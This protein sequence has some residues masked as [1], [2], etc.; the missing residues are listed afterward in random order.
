[1][2]RLVFKIGF[3]FTILSLCYSCIDDVDFDQAGDLAVTTPLEVSLIYFEEP[4][5]TFY[6]SEGVEQLVVVD[7]TR[8][9]IFN[10]DFVSDNLVRAN[11]LFETTNSI[12]RIFE[13]KIDFLDEADQELRAI[14]FS[15]PASET[16]QP[17]VTIH[18]EIFENETLVDLKTTTQLV[19]TLTMLAN[20]DGT[21]LNENS[22]GVIKMRSKGSFYINVISP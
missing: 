8:V 18:E 16:G 5:A 6:V 7:S 17:Q 11:F 13:A 19:L 1:M 15:V 2:L 10:D 12:N 4:A 21:T 3:F 14:E 9:T 20:P 22:P